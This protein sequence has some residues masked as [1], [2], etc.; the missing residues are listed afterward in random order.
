MNWPHLNLNQLRVFAVVFETASMTAAAKQLSL[1][2]SGV[3]QHIRALEADIGFPLFDRVGRNILPN[4]LAKSL[5]REVFNHIPLLAQKLKELGQN[6]VALSGCVR[7]G[8]PIEFGNN[9]VIPRL[10]LI[11]LE[12]QG[13]DFDVT[14]DYATELTRLLNDG[15]LD[16]AIADE[17]PPHRKMSYETIAS[18][19]LWLCASRE[20]L[21][22]KGRISMQ[23]AFLESLDYVDY[24]K[25]EPLLRRWFHHHLRHKKWQIRT[26]AHIMDVQGV[27]KFILNG[28]GAGILPDHLVKKLSEEGHKLVVIE[29]R[30]TPLKNTLQMVTRNGVELNQAAQYTLQRLRLLLKE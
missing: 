1:T 14:L 23:R 19:E 5:Y 7:I 12:E 24:K 13:I 11:G 17:L 26:R 29:G 25:G 15:H 8:M 21:N 20:Y 4:P 28:I 30:A 2:Q 9:L 22:T 27:A 3:S 6:Q 18:E 10:T 16:F